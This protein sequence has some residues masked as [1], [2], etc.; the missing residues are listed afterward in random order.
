[1]AESFDDFCRAC[2]DLLKAKR[3]KYVIVGGVAVTAVGEPR[4]TGD[5]D[6]IVFT[7]LD[8]LR[9]LL[10]L[11]VGRGFKAVI[12]DE[13]ETASAGGSV[14]LTRGKFHFDLIVRSLFIEDQALERSRNIKVFRRTVRF[15][16]PEDLLVLKVVAGRTRDL[17]DAEG[18]WRR[19]GP[20]LDRAYVRRTLQKLCDLA[21]DHVYLERWRR[22]EGGK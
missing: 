5:L 2:I 17:L 16:S 10:E 3:T 1:M 15:P 14:R 21:E 6:A 11:A 7:D 18:I 19:H 20:A 13:I 12:E 4:F 9:H 22:L 8:E